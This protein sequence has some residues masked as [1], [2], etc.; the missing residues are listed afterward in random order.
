MSAE[1][2]E[3]TVDVHVGRLRRALVRGREKDPIRTVRGAG[4]SL[5]ETLLR[6]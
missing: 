3:R 6:G 4:Y 2:D 1:I 5:D